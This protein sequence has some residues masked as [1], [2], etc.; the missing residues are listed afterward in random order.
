MNSWVMIR[1]NLIFASPRHQGSLT[2]LEKCA[3]AQ[4]K[5][6]EKVLISNWLINILQT[7]AALD[8]L[9]TKCP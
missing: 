2:H 5:W 3:L 8:V 9:Q 6:G 7:K 1:Q 4:R